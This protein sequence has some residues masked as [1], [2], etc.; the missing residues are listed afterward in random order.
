[1]KTHGKKSNFLH[2]KS[3]QKHLD[4]SSLFFDKKETLIQN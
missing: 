3:R 2:L 4:F 1:M